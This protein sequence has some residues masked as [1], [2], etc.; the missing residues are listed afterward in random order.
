MRFWAMYAACRERSLPIGWIGG[1][2]LVNLL[3]LYSMKR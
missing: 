2:Y 1:Y 3:I